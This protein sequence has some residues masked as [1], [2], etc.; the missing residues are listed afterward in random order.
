MPAFI[1]F[2]FVCVRVGVLEHGYLV[3]Y[4]GNRARYAV[5]CTGAMFVLLPTTHHPH[6]ATRRLLHP[7]GTDVHLLVV[8]VHYWRDIAALQP[9]KEGWRAHSA[10]ISFAHVDAELTPRP[11]CAVC[12][13]AGILRPLL[14]RVLGLAGRAAHH[15]PGILAVA[16]TKLPK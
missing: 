1:D 13:F 3:Q 7:G 14:L 6:G 11:S 4:L 2:L 8:C 5:I 10:T 9:T 16:A 15:L 12:L